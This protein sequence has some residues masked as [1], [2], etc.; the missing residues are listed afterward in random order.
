MRIR[1]SVVLAAAFVAATLCLPTA[2]TASQSRL[3]FSA[4]LTAPTP[5]PRVG[6]PWRYAVYVRDLKG[7][8]IQAV[9]KEQVVLRGTTRTIDVIGWNKFF[10][11][12]RNTYR[13]PAVDRGKSLL[14][15]I[16]VLGPGGTKIIN[17]P[18][19]VQ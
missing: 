15:Q 4:T 1:G 2:G 18:I 16:R 17:Y 14:F 19:R 7:R 5:T 12:R 3:R 8:R 6:E 11:V 10:G 13:W 9:A